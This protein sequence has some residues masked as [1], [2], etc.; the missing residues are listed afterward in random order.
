MPDT[1]FC[2]THHMLPVTLIYRHSS[3]SWSIDNIIADLKSRDI[4]E[5][6][7][8]DAYADQADAADDKVEAGKKKAIRDDMWNRSGDAYRSYTA[9]TGSRVNPGGTAAQA[10]RR[11]KG[12]VSKSPSL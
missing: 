12:S 4:W 1:K 6:G 2:I 10:A 9:R 8:G 3:A 7:G 11:D 5:A